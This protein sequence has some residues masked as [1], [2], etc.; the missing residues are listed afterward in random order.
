MARKP[1]RLAGLPLWLIGAAAALATLAVAL[2]V[3]PMLLPGPPARQG[4]ET[5]V[6]A[7][8]GAGLNQIAAILED[9]GVIASRASFIGFARAVGAADQLKAGEYAIPSRASMARI[10]AILASGKSIQH[11]ITIPEGW[12]SAMALR[13]IAAAEFL[14]GPA[15]AP[16]PEGALLPATY[17]FTRGTSRA[18]AVAEMK[19]AHEA[20]IADLWPQRAKD[21]PFSTI[22]EAITLASIV[23]KETAEAEE[24]PRVAAVFVNRLRLGMKLESDPTIIYGVTKGEPL[25]RRIRRS[26]IEM[27]HPWNTYVIAGLPP[28]PIANPG[29]EAIAAV[30][31]PP[32]TDELFFVADGTGGHA[33][34]R[35]YAEHNANVE[36][37]RAIQR[38]RGLRKD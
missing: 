36:R 18:E 33:F 5:V 32:R 1:P 16:P 13:R 8:R 17:F 15:P 12:T 2:F 26:E 35:T 20:V 38:E 25:G 11:R 27:A 6:M 23:E 37:W 14:D 30:L 31:N 28:T 4:E 21:L 22:E 9:E 10:V 7:P 29:R 19:E 24:R 3:A 34:A